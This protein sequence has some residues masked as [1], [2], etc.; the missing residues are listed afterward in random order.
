MLLQYFYFM[1]FAMHSKTRACYC[2][3]AGKCERWQM[4]VRVVLLLSL[5]PSSASLLPFRWRMR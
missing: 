4:C 2:Q 1:K 3:R 5:C